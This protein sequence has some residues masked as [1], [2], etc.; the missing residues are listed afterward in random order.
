M[1]IQGINNSKSQR[2]AGNRYP[3][4]TSGSIQTRK[5]HNAKQTYDT[6]ETQK[7]STQEEKEEQRPDATFQAAI[8]S[9]VLGG[10]SGQRWPFQKGQALQFSHISLLTT[11]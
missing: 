2:S 5:P 7:Q 3:Q 8:A 1:Q 10:L 6:Q 9:W 11:P 4:S